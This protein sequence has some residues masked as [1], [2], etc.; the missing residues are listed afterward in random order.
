MAEYAIP[1]TDP[2]TKPTAT[3]GSLKWAK[4]LLWV[5]ILALIALPT[6]LLLGVSFMRSSGGAI[7]YEFTLANYMRLFQS[8]SFLTLLGKTVL[9]AAGSSIVAAMIAF[10]M[11]YYA[12]RVLSRGRLTAVLLVIIPL[13]ISMLMRVFAWKLILGERGIL[14]SFL[15]WT[16]ILDTPSTAFLYTG[17]SV[18]LTFIYI[19]IPFIF[20]SAY[21]A[22]ERIPEN[23]LEAARDSGA[24]PIRVITTVVWPLARPGVAIGVALAFL[25][26]VGDYITPSMVGGL[27]GTMV[28][29][30]IASQFGIASNWPFG[31]AMALVLMLTVVAFLAITFLLARSQGILTGEDG[32]KSVPTRR[33][34]VKAWIG[35]GL[36]VLPYLFLY[37]PLLVIVLFSFNSNGIQ[38]FPLESFTLQWYVQMAGDSPMMEALRRS[39]FIG[40]S[41]L[42]LSVVMGTGFAVMLGLGKI[43]HAAWVEKLLAIPVALPGVV[44]GVTLVLAFKLLNVP[45]GIPSVI[46]GHASF[47]MPV[48]M[49]IVLS[50]LRRLDPSLV[51]A[52]YDLGADQWRTFLHVLFPLIR[53][54][55]LGG[56]LLGFTLSVDEVIVTLF[57]AG[58]EPTLP[59]WVWNQMRFGF[60]PAMN[61]IFTCI[62][63]VTL[64][65]ILVAQR[66]IRE[67]R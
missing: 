47:V 9:V 25:M 14:N 29:T 42:V 46:L 37:A 18:F 21:A 61:A 22:L 40:A 43:A 6:L 31:G 5:W 34:G 2:Q 65:L 20:V 54:A 24:G 48:V 27:N 58:T 15:V 33:T 12:S 57:L 39:L 59:V 23:L 38:T 11:A 19:S 62:G 8:A 44:L 35:A 67:Q 66:L 28:G 7:V 50:R 53:S 56:A 36:F 60:T 64:V 63:G 17:F 26:S 10:P 41:V 13:W 3:G 1:M 45:Q 30:V 51:E 32:G 55:I 52:S 49:M 16:G 4:P